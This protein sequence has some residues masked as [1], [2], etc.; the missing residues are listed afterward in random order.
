MKIVICG[1]IDFTPQIVTAADFLRAAG[2][3]VEV[4]RLTQRI[5]AGELTYEEFLKEKAAHGDGIFRTAEPGGLIRRYYR[6]IAEAAA[7]LVINAEKRG[8]A[9]Y[10]GANTFLEIGF[11]HALQKKIYLLNPPAQGYYDDELAEIAP[12]IIFGNLEL[13]K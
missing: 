7:I 1:S 9:G 13:I 4:P 10:I 3:E 11:A 12:L 5:I 2:H 6:L 8:V